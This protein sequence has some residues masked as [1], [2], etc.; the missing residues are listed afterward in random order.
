[1]T[2]FSSIRVCAVVTDLNAATGRFK[3]QVVP[4]LDQ[5]S[6]SPPRPSDAPPLLCGGVPSPRCASSLPAHGGVV[7]APAASS[8]RVHGVVAAG[9]ERV[10]SLSVVSVTD[11]EVMLQEDPTGEHMRCGIYT[12]VEDSD[13]QSKTAPGAKSRK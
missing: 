7:P 10:W 12:T 11:E 8:S 9:G 3:S 6:S 13:H 5:L 1:M 4:A 2:L